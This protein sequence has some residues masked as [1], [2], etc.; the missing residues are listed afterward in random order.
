MDENNKN[1]SL[2]Y[3]PDIKY[4]E[5][6]FSNLSEKYDY[7]QYI[8][9]KPNDSTN[10]YEYDD[11]IKEEIQ[12]NINN[13][14]V[15]IPML[16][17]QLQTNINQVFKP[18]FNDWY[19]ELIDK[20]YPSSFPTRDPIVEYDPTTPTPPSGGEGNGG[21]SGESGGGSS[22]IIEYD[23]WDPIIPTPP[24]TPPSGGSGGNGGYDPYRPDGD[25]GTKGVT[26]DGLWDPSSDYTID[27]DD[28]DD[29][30]SIIERIENEYIRNIL[31]LYNYFIAELCEILSKFISNLINVTMPHVQKYD[32][33]KFLNNDIDL[34]A[35]ETSKQTRHLIDAALRSE[36]TGAIKVDFM[37]NVFTLEG[38][39]FQL[40][41][42]KSAYELKLRY[43]STDITND[44][45]RTDAISNRILEG[46][47]SIYNRKYETAYINL[48]K[49]LNSFVQV[50]EDAFNTICAG[51]KAKGVYIKKGGIN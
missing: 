38:T 44:G 26:D 10:G 7:K 29:I 37:S 28:D 2:I 41:S 39:L 51:V 34:K 48:Y 15:L 11:S 21:G 49:Y 3:K 20:Q 18:I 30:N 14:V 13:I 31:D 12:N 25:D 19:K 27:F 16:N 35:S 22:D 50:T 47:R 40:K 4:T 5:D 32:A 36:V 45:S 33:I 42:F 6:Y 46:S 9:Y 8:E 1:K 43:E 23:P 24:P 17:N